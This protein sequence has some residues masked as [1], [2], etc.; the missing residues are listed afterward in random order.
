MLAHREIRSTA[1]WGR[2]A[3]ARVRGSRFTY[4]AF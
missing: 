4:L 3:L 1:R 2:L